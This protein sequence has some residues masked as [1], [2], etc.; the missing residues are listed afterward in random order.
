MRNRDLLIKNREKNN[1]VRQEFLDK[2]S[3]IEAIAVDGIKKRHSEI[4]DRIKELQEEKQ[5]LLDIPATKKEVLQSA[6]ERLKA[7]RDEVI[8][9]F[10]VPHL[11]G[12]QERNVE[13]F[14]GHS[15][16]PEFRDRLVI[17][18][19]LTEKDIE[20]A[21]EMLPEAGIDEKKRLAEVRRIDNE[22]SGLLKILS[23]ELE[24]QG[25]K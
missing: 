19:A 16:L 12:C 13:M 1:E 8:L 7:R 15:I 6:R 23:D 11:L 18:L 3:K 5:K 21:M 9:H 20:M 14:G 17:W 10:L 22:I 2:S 25:S 24:K 4:E